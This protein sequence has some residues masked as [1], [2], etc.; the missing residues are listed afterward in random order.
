MAPLI[1]HSG[2]G[3][4]SWQR[5]QLTDPP[6]TNIRMRVDFDLNYGPR[7]RVIT[8]TLKKDDGITLGDMFHK[9]VDGAHNVFALDRDEKLQ[10]TKTGKVKAQRTKTVR[11]LERRT[12]TWLNGKV[13]GEGKLSRLVVYADFEGV[14]FPCEEEWIE[15]TGKACERAVSGEDTTEDDADDDADEESTGASSAEGEDM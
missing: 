15:I 11:A 1:K 14:A 3:P 13:V 10:R 2:S 12:K 4:A 8:T 7:Y 5:L 9:I 6:C